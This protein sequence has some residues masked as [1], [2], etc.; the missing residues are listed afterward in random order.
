MK[1]SILFL[2]LSAA[3]LLALIPSTAA[4]EAIDGICGVS[5]EWSLAGGVLTVTG[6]GKMTDY[7]DFSDVPWRA[8]AASIRE[9]IL[10]EGLTSIGSKA[11]YQC[12]MLESISIPSTVVSIGE[13][14]FKGC[15]ALPALT[16]PEGLTSLGRRALEGCS[17]ITSLLLP[18]SLSEWGAGALGQCSSLQKVEVAQDNRALLAEDGALYTAN[19]KTL[20]AYPAGKAD[21]A[22]ALPEGVEEIGNGALTGVSALRRLYLPASVAHVADGALLS[23]KNLQAFYFG[24]T[25]EAFASLSAE[26][27]TGASASFSHAHALAMTCSVP[28]ECGATAPHR[29]EYRYNSDATCF[30]DGTKTAACKNGCGAVSTKAAIGTAGHLWKNGTCALCEQVCAHETVQDC[31][32]TLCGRFFAP[33]LRL[34]NGILSVS[35]DNGATWTSLGRVSGEAGRD[36]VTPL[37]RI[38]P[39]TNEWELSYDGTAW[40]SLGVKATGSVGASG[41]DAVA[42]SL[43]IH[44]TTNEWEL[45]CD[46][47]LTWISLG[48]KATGENGKDGQNGQNGIDGKDHARGM[49]IA[50]ISVAGV[51][52]LGS[53][54]LLFWHLYERKTRVMVFRDPEDQERTF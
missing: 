31:L 45:S 10:P 29:F 44:P 8:Y 46:G 51:S 1:R 3:L 37:L 47:G 35:R 48:V 27:P 30:T 36:G 40:T 11:F 25:A 28:C 12:E 20:L 19:G 32:C 39:T 50:A 42:P 7:A 13:C 49:A 16:L 33:L 26:L 43:R 38:N 22:F 24:G 21:P 14:A 23:L 54:A 34:E 15:S 2:L 6:E 5:L 41:A 53:A 4:E 18:A 9:V 52:I 17:A